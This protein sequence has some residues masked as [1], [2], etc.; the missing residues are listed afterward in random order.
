M[1][2]LKQ[3][4]DN[5]YLVSDGEMTNPRTG[6][7]TKN[8]DFIA[9][10]QQLE[11]V[12]VWNIGGNMCVALPDDPVYITKEQAMKFFNLVEAPQK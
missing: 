1:S 2:E 3:I 12:E 4:G 9:N 5:N 8:G 7:N 6:F 11:P 10:R